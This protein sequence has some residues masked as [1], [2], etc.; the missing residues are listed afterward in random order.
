MG[1]AFYINGPTLVL[2]KGN[3]ALCLSGSNPFGQLS[4]LGLAVDDVRVFPVFRHANVTVTDF[5]PDVPVETLWMV[6]EVNITMNLVHFDEYVLSAWMTETMG[7][8]VPRVGGVSML[9]GTGIL[10]Q[11]GTPMG[12][13]KPLFASGN[14][15]VSLN[16]ASPYLNRPWRFPTTYLTQ[17]PIEISLG[18]TRSAVRLH[19]KAIPYIFPNSGINTYTVSQPAT[20]LAGGATGVGD[21]SSSG[22]ALWFR[23]LD[24]P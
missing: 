15:Y 18:T 1:R 16:L 20:G 4:Q 21:I 24:T 7:G 5:G 2:V 8:G 3:G 23:T 9:P 13:G 14:H 6:A 12:G 17:Q 11:A 19:V 22:A 10:P